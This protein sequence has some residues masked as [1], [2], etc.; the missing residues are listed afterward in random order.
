MA[1]TPL[2]RLAS[3]DEIADTIIHICSP[4]AS[5]MTGSTIVIDG[6]VTAKL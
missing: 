4:S 3:T 6:G 2:K 5:F 1:Q